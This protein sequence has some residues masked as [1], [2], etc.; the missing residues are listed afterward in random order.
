[1]SSEISLIYEFAVQ[2]CQGYLPC[3]FLAHVPHSTCSSTVCEYQHFCR[4]SSLFPATTQLCPLLQKLWVNVHYLG[5]HFPK[6]FS[7][8][9]LP[10]THFSILF[11]SMY[12]CTYII[13]LPLMKAKSSR[14]NVK[15]D[16]NGKAWLV[17]EI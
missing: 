14:S 6:V 9:R 16:N 5:H 1:M 13:C 17:L 7:D 4:L 2:F 8:N 3:R 11:F 15:V 10:W 12:V